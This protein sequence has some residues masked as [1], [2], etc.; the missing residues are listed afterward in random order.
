MRAYVRPGAAVPEGF[1]SDDPRTTLGF[2]VVKARDLAAG[3]VLVGRLGGTA[4]VLSRSAS[5]GKGLDYS[6][7]PTVRVEVEWGMLIFRHDEEV[8]VVPR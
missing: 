3:D 5:Q 2:P 4:A 1:L 7:H 6:F 8:S